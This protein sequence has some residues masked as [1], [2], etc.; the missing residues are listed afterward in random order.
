MRG[1]R[2]GDGQGQGEHGGGRELAGLSGSSPDI[3]HRHAR[4]Q[5]KRDDLLGPGHPRVD[6][7]PDAGHD[8]VLLHQDAVN[9]ELR[10]GSEHVGQVRDGNN[11]FGNRPPAAV[12]TCSPARSEPETMS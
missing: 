11:L 1:W 6:L 5:M 2:S 12:R 4:P 7:L 8:M 9:A 3:E 10:C